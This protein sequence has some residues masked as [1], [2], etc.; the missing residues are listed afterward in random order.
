MRGT[1]KSSLILAAC[2]ALTAGQV[3]GASGSWTGDGSD[4]DWGTSGNWSDGTIPGS[5]S[6]VSSDTANVGRVG[7]PAFVPSRTTIN[8]EQDWYIGSIDVW[9]SADITISSTGGHTLHWDGNGNYVRQSHTLTIDVPV[10]ST[11][12]I[13]ASPEQA[14]SQYIFNNT[15]TFAA[16]ANPE[17]ASL[18]FLAGVGDVIFNAPITGPAHLYFNGGTGRVILNATN[19][20]T[21]QS[22]Q[23]AAL[24]NATNQTLVLNAPGAWTA[25]EALDVWR[26]GNLE[27]TAAN[28]VT[29]T[30]SI[31]LGTLPGF[32][33]LMTVT[34]SNDYSGGTNVGTATGTLLANNPNDGGSATGSGNVSIHGTLGGNGYIIN[35]GDNGV[36]INAGGML[37]P[38]A[39]DGVAGTLTITTGSAGL[40][41]SRAVGATNSA[42][43][44]F[45]L[46]SPDNSDQVVLAG[47]TQ[48]KIGS[49]NLEWDDFVFNPLAGFSAG[50]YTLVSSAATISGSLGSN[51]TGTIG[52]LDATL[53]FANNNQDLV[54][55]VVPEPGTF[56]VLAIGAMGLLARRR[57]KV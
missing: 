25:G 39:S 52:G 1:T 35:S 12:V 2:A 32:T 27:I 26:G 3:M 29:G 19:N 41:I 15:V 11:S 43:L 9:T 51:L 54:L 8:L 23:G 21:G 30:S 4:N 37:A 5:T 33:Q 46:G 22:Q 20:F 49:G 50:T 16:S 17:T 31:K 36:R 48:L 47:T 7:N 55:T 18:Q 38:G 10:V 57:R 28:A 40:D 34:A 14:G 42:S 13:R 53:A 45:D 6:G 24:F 44:L 56:G